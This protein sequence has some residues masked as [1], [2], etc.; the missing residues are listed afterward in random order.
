MNEALI[1]LLGSENRAWNNRQHFL[2][3]ASQAMRRVLVD[4]ARARKSECRT[5]PFCLK[6][7]DSSVD[8]ISPHV[9][10]VHIAL[11]EFAS[12]APRQ[13][14]LVELRFFGGLS[15]DEAAQVVGISARWADRDWALAKAW[16]RR[17]LS[18]TASSHY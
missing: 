1:R 4:Y 9:L 11:E 3:A 7:T 10:D 5:A 2:A 16:L 18:G 15:L 13:A 14:Q 17:R 8:S 6:N 12:I